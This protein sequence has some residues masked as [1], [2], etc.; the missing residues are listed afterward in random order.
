MA[1]LDIDFEEFGKF[2]TTP[3]WQN[4][5]ETTHPFSQLLRTGIP[6]WSDEN[7]TL[8]YQN[9]KHAAER[10][11]IQYQTLLCLAVL[12]CEG[13]ASEKAAA[14]FQ[15]VNP[16]GE[17][18]EAITC[19]DNSWAQTLYLLLEIAVTV[20]QEGTTTKVGDSETRKQK[21]IDN[22]KIMRAMVNH[23]G[24]GELD[25]FINLLFDQENK[26]TREEF[27]KAM[28]C[29][30]VSWIFESDKIREKFDFWNKNKEINL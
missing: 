23:E 10:E 30:K 4:V 17:A 21:R 29:S 12:W 6:E 27:I 26:Y 16:P 14:L 15:C 20:A 24:E 3:A 22:R 9:D 18:Q 7:K 5:F 25:G 8:M 13:D 2:F 19:T 11:T 1:K 28:G